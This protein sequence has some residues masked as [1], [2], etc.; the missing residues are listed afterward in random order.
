[1]TLIESSIHLTSD[2]LEVEVL[3]DFLGHT[4]HREKFCRKDSGHRERYG[5]DGL[6]R[7]L[8]RRNWINKYQENV[9][10]LKNLK[11]NIYVA[12]SLVFSLESVFKFAKN[13]E[14]KIILYHMM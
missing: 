7:A 6:G 11:L 5:A 1:M 10:M 3:A 2:H 13:I 4:L 9:K 12:L 14:K 8:L